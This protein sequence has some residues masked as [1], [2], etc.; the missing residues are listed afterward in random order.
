M[1]F[2]AHIITIN[3]HAISEAA[4]D[5]CIMS[6]DQ[7]KNDFDIEVYDAVT[8]PNT[9]DMINKYGLKWNYPWEGV[10]LDMAA[11]LRKS[12]YRT[13]DPLARIACALS[14]Y[15]LW[16]RCADSEPMMVLEHD[17]RFMHKV[18][19]E[20]ILDT[21]FNIVGINDPIGATRRARL[22]AEKIQTANKFVTPVPSIDNFDV[23]QGLAG[24]SAYIIKP[25]G[26]KALIKAV[27]DYGLWPNDAIMCKQLIKRM[28]VTKKY[29]TV[30]QGLPSTTTD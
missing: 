3:N 6:H 19:Y 30:V 25:A 12:A 1:A 13:A 24:N 16:V 10:E 26:A 11:G 20:K 27:K 15:D 2:K 5:A 28:G 8:P 17:A 4:S 21:N 18:P 9:G 23:P 29:Y 22:F 7:V 14:H